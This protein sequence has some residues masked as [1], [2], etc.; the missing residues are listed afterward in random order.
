MLRVGRFLRVSGF[1]TRF[2]AM[3]LPDIDV[4]LI[5]RAIAALPIASAVRPHQRAG[6]Q[7]DGASS[8]M[9][10]FASKDRS[11]A[12]TRGIAKA[13]AARLGHHPSRTRGRLGIPDRARPPYNA[14]AIVADLPD[15]HL[16]TRQ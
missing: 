10:R 3:P 15:P 11:G 16:R 7:S 9:E 8:A 5:F 4:D 13:T 1:A 2:A 6:I 14:H 12:T